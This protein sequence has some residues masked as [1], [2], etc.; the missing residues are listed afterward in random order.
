MIWLPHNEHEHDHDLGLE[1]D[2]RQ[3][4]AR[5]AERRRLLG[6][7]AGGAGAMLLA[8]C[9]G[10][11]S[12]TSDAS[13]GSGTSTGT[14]SSTGTST[15]TTTGSGTVSS[16][17]ADPTETNGPYPSD[18]TNSVNGAVSNVLLQSGVVRSDIRSSFGISSGTAPGVPLTLNIRLVNANA[19]CA[20]LAGFAIYIWHCTRDGLYSLY[21]SGVTGE[22]FLRGVQAA[23]A[24]GLL[25]FTTIFPGCYAGRYP[26]I[27]F[28]VFT[29]LGT[30]TGYVNRVLV[31]QMALP[32]AICSEVYAS[33]TGYAASATNFA[34]TSI[35]SDNVFGDNTAAQIAQQTPTLSGSI[36]TGFTGDIVVGV[37]Y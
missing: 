14:G 19:A 33:A 36:S 9:G 23:D 21:S 29:S 11:G 15:G 28:E 3:I 20:A 30:A 16:C 31:S 25:Q 32:A 1:H 18:G 2:L 7:L 34:R 12:A 4:S 13:S 5:V 8:G 22:N 24:N 35:A 17:V 27:H 6:M 26:H 10:E 37:P